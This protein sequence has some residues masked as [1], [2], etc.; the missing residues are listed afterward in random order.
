MDLEKA[1][2]KL[3]KVTEKIR[4]EEKVVE[5]NAAD[6]EKI[7]GYEIIEEKITVSDSSWIIIAIVI[8]LIGLLAA[9]WRKKI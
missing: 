7:E 6:K 1:Q 9:G 4:Q 2:E 5:G 3:A 8:G